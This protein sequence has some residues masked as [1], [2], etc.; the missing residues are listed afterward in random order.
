MEQ[1]K[2]V[3]FSFFISFL[4]SFVLSKL[5]YSYGFLDIPF[6]RK[7]HPFP[8]ALGGGMAI[9]LSLTLSSM[10]LGGPYELL[11]F[12]S[13]L[14][15]IGLVDDIFDLPA[16]LKL[17]FQFMIS[18]V[19]L[20]YKPFVLLGDPFLDFIG[21]LLWIVV[22]I[23]AFNIIDGIDG[24]ASGVAILSS[25]GLAIEGEKFALLIIGASIG[26]F[27]LNYPPARIFLGDAGAYLLGFLIGSLSLNL[28]KDFSL[29]SISKIF[30]LVL[31]PLIDITWTVLRR[32]IKGQPAMVGDEKHIHHFLRRK[33]GGKAAL[34]VLLLVQ[35]MSVLIGVWCF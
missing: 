22:L 11:I 15:M 8:V 7:G 27:V 4:L 19:W 26:F 6:E 9:F 30:F 24:L 35:G 5:A 16:F 13:V 18:T 34:I 2:M 17:V 32:W 3:L 20:I 21:G 28:L 33:L 1:S 31:F 14:I 29:P 23:N 25:I 12:S 10:I